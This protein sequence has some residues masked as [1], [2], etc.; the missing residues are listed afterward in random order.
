MR[1]RELK[2]A[3]VKKLFVA[4]DCFHRHRFIETRSEPLGIELIIG[5]AS[6]YDFSDDIFGAV[7]QYPSI[8]GE[9]NDYREFVQRVHD[10]GAW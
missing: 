10:K 3:D 9:V 2:K 7:I 4:E 6:N 5:D 1:S 8:N